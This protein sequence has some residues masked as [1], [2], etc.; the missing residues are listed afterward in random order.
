MEQTSKVGTHKTTVGTI[1]GMTAVTY[2]RTVVIK[3]DNE[4]I[5][6]NSGGWM[7]NTTKLRINQAATQFNLPV[8]VYQKQGTWF[9]V[10]DRNWNN[11]IPF[12]DGMTINR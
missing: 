12:V 9:V 6:L 11:P 4:K 1:D 2:H 3:W 8:S 10:K 5:V 7:S